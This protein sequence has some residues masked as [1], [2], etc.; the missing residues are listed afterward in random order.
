MSSNGHHAELVAS[1][2]DAAGEA[3]GTNVR[4]RAEVVASV[5]IKLME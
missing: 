4:I 2:R 3:D 5:F 1:L